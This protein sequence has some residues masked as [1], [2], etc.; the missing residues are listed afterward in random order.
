[1]KPSYARCSPLVYPDQLYL[2]SIDSHL[3]RQLLSVHCLRNLS[4]NICVQSRESRANLFHVRMGQFES[5]R[6]F[7]KSFGVVILQLD[8][9][10]TDTMMQPIKQA[11]RPNTQF[12]NSFSLHPSTTV[13]K[14][15]QRGNQYALLE[16]DTLIATKRTVASTGD[17]RR[18][19]QGY[20]K[21]GE[22]NET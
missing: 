19:S 3:T 17:P 5:I 16:D 8:I 1:M 15:F 9:V 22:M 21:R 12:L 20:G 14:L 7:M 2:G 6:D 10:S 13:G 18:D 4:P 11:I